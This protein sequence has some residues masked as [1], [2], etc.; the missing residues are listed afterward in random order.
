M[1]YSKSGIVTIKNVPNDAEIT[2]H[3]LMIRSGMIK[4]LASGLYTWMPLGLKV[5]RKIEDIIRSEMD[6]VNALE[7][8]MP[9]IQP[10]EL[11]KESGRWD[12]YGPE[13]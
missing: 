10:S 1:K 6:K 5:L 4:K 11:W 7:I 3:I 9:A 12:K 13:Y 8:L 2:S